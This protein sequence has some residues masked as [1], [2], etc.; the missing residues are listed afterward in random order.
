MSVSDTGGEDTRELSPLMSSRYVSRCRCRTAMLPRLRPHLHLH[1]HPPLVP[2]APS[3]S[4]PSLSR[5][6]TGVTACATTL[7]DALRPPKSTHPVILPV[8]VDATVSLVAPY[9]VVH[10]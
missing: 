2:R 3:S 9:D 5:R 8:T 7:L 6:R 10:G 4:L 1:P